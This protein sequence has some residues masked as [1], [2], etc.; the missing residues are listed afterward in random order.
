MVERIIIHSKFLLNLYYWCPISPIDNE[1]TLKAATQHHNN[2]NKK[3]ALPPPTDI[4]GRTEQ[5]N[6]IRHPQAE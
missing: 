3:D 1:K 2:H 5:R 4:I 6:N